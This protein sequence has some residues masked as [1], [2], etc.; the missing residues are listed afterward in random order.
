MATINALLVKDK[1]QMNQ[2]I[3]LLVLL[4]A[5]LT[6]LA[7]PSPVYN[8]TPTRRALMWFLPGA[9]Y[10]PYWSNPEIFADDRS[11]KTSIYNGR[12]E[13][14]FDGRG[15]RFVVKLSNALMSLGRV[16]AGSITSST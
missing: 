4:S 16:W 1:V 10:D 6:A 3:V 9:L 12:F 5:L 7:A 8:N 11:M 13:C 15:S 14:F 2:K